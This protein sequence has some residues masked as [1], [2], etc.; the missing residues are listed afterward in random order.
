MPDDPIENIPPHDRRRFFAAGLGRI[1]RPLADYVEK[2]IPVP[3]AA[4][5]TMLRPPGA[6]E[7][8]RFLETCLR[9]GKCADSCPANAIA[10]SASSDPRIKGTP[11]VEPARQACVICEDLSCMKVCP[12]GALTLVDRFAIRMGIAT[13][14]HSVCA[15]T[16]GENCTICVEKCPLGSTAIYV[17]D[18]GRIAVID[19]KTT[20]TG[21]T[22]CGVC[23]Q[24]CPTRPV[25]AIRVM[26]CG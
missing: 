20:G 2:R 4:E 3:L 19:P 17:D 21:C 23:E 8:S 24:Y 5:R 25:R 14:D 10:L 22:G 6:M 15:R 1:L 7:E 16:T 26:P 12:S 9:C 18:D 11:Y 13:V